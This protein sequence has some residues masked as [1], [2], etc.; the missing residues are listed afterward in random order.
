VSGS[1]VKSFTTRL[2]QLQWH[3]NEDRTR[4]FLVLRV[5]DSNDELMKLLR[6]CNSVADMYDQP[7]LYEEDKAGQSKHKQGVQVNQEQESQAAKKFHVS[8]A[9]SLQRPSES[10][11]A[12]AGKSIGDGADL[13]SSV[14]SL[15]VGFG[16]VKVRIGQD[17]TSLSLDR[18]RRRSSGVL[19]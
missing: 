6:A 14:R 1:G 8:I 9:W 15:S 13:P 2:E 11:V 17:V 16:E 12:N 7:R 4:W 19:S 18:K 10:G 3:P 5:A